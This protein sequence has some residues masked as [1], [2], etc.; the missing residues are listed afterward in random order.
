M[1]TLASGGHA[2][3]ASREAVQQFTFGAAKDRMGHAACLFRLFRLLPAVCS[4]KS[5]VEGERPLHN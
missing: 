3:L 2:V 1:L 4:R 5:G